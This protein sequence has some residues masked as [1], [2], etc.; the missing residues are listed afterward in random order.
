MVYHIRQRQEKAFQINLQ[1]NGQS[2]LN[3]MTGCNSA[4]TNWYEKKRMKI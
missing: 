1:K 2:N 3:G 4:H